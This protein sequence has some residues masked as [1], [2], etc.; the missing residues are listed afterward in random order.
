MVRNTP[1]TVLTVAF[2]V[3][4]ASVTGVDRNR[5]TIGPG[6]VAWIEVTPLSASPA[7]N[8]A[9]QLTATLQDE[10]GNVINHR[11]VTWSSS[12]PVVATVSSRGLVTGVAPGP[13]L[14]RAAADGKTGTAVVTVP[15]GT[16]GEG[17]PWV[18]PVLVLKYFPIEDGKIDQSITGDWGEA[19]DFTRRK[20]DSVTVELISALESGSA[21]LRY[22]SENVQPSLRYSVVQTVEHVAALPTFVKARHTVPMTAY[23]KIL[24]SNDVGH[25]VEKE[26]VKEVWIWGYHGGVIDLWESNMAGPWGDI[27]NSSRDLND[28]P[29]LSKTYTVYHYNYQ[30]GIAEAAENH[31]HQIEHVL[32]FVD[33]R[34]STPEDEWDGLLFWG[35]WVGSDKSHRIVDPGCGWSHIPYNGEKDYDWTNRRFVDTDCED[36]EPHGGGGRRSYNCERWG[37]TALGWFVYWMQNIPG[38][39]NALTYNGKSLTNWWIFI[40]NFDGAMARGLKLVER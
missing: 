32:N 25:W 7:I 29:V 10:D 15:P 17:A 18:I 35:R 22:R 12:N 30:R 33:G 9:V 27:S 14:I 5:E 40:G 3:L 21:Y 31:M 23:Y 26:G 39:G 37:C 36:W 16:T 28:L 2:A 34:D 8:G 24:S 6:Q 20:T 11:A 38:Q 19:L 4:V 1:V 13:T